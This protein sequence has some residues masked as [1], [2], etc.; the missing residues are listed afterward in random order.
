MSLMENLFGR[1]D[2]AVEQGELLG[3][4]AL[5]N[6]A[7][8]PGQR[9]AQL[10]QTRDHPE[11]VGG[12]LTVGETAGVLVDAHH[13]Q[14]GFFFGGFDSPLGE[15]VRHDGAGRA[16]RSEDGGV[17]LDGVAAFL[18]VVVDE[19]D[20][21]AVAL[22]E[23]PD[24]AEAGRGRGVDHHRVLDGL[25]AGA[26]ELEF[27]EG[28]AGVG[29]KAPDR[30]LV[31]TGEEDLVVGIEPNRTHRRGEGVEIGREMGRDDP[32]GFIVGD[33]D[34][35]A[36]SGWRSEDEPQRRKDR[37]EPQSQPIGR[38]AQ[39]P[40]GCDRFVVMSSRPW[41]LRGSTLRWRGAPGRCP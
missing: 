10:H 39:R 23:I 38:C 19:I 5:E 8:H 13:Q 33:V 7:A 35:A 22:D 29:E 16:H 30:G 34:G 26:A 6:P 3:L 25:A 14:R 37:K 4:E 36:D 32:H 2:D 40:I 17:G 9:A 18:L 1:F 12:G 24:L 15:E 20:G 28:Q 27:G 11:V 41:R 31:R 21:A